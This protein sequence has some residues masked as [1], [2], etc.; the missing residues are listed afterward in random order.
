MRGGRRRGREN[1]ID[2]PSLPAG[3]RADES[4]AIAAGMNEGIED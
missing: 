3:E 4:E 1:G 2:S